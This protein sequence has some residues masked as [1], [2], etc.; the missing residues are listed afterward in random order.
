[1]LKLS[2]H[3]ALQRDWKE[4][5]SKTLAFLSRTRDHAQA[6]WPV[7]LDHC[8]ARIILDNAVGEGKERW[9]ERLKRPAIKHMT[10]EQLAKAV[11]LGKHIAEGREDLVALDL[12]S[13]EVRGK[14]DK[15]HNKPSSAHQAKHRDC[16]RLESSKNFINKKNTM[17]RKDPGKD[18][19]KSGLWSSLASSIGIKSRKG[20]SVANSPENCG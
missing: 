15:K 16:I 2:D 13:L 20:G 19:I 17:K 12:Q 10:C 3:V 8:F 4:L 18:D 14:M 1:M 7:T 11:E 5:F 6:K 9:N